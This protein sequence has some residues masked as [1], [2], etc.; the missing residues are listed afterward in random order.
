MSRRPS[1]LVPQSERAHYVAQV[2]SV[3]PNGPYLLG[4]WSLGG[5]VA[6]EMAQ[7]LQRQGQTVALLAMLEGGQAGRTS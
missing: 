6:F 5:I 1:I 7:Q 3:Q 2:Q 4:G